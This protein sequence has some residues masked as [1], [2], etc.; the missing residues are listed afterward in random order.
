MT[1]AEA[2]EVLKATFPDY[3]LALDAT[4]PEPAV[5]ASPACL[6]EVATRLRDDP[7]LAFD[8]LMCLSGVESTDG[9][10]TVYH[11]YSMKVGHKLTL[12]CVVSRD[13]PEIPS[14]SHIWPGAEWFEREVYDMYGIKFS[15]HPDL[16]R[17]L[18]PDDW[19][20]YPL[21]KDYV[22]PKFY[23]DIPVT[24]EVPKPSATDS[25]SA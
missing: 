22:P 13:H 12:R 1:P 3:G 15:G 9:F 17:I 8:C 4:V 11:L 14:V 5:V 7:R 6:A 16:R 19:E 10:Q 20:G 24:V 25:V 18:C 21:R 2:L 23:H